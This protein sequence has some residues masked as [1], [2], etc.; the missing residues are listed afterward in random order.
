MIEPIPSSRSSPSAAERMRL[1][2]KRRRIG[3]RSVRI[4]L[5]ATDI[6]LLI[7]K[8]C[9]EPSQS[10]NTEALQEAVSDLFFDLSTYPT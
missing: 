4:L 3:F 1:H 8:G 6:Q 10:E 7:R 5:Q 9:L 2:R